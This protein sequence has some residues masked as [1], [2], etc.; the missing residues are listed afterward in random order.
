[1]SPYLMLSP[2][3]TSL[4]SLENNSSPNEKSLNYNYLYKPSAEAKL[5]DPLQ[6]LE[7]KLLIRELQ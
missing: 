3:E 1:M 6:S 4:W 2:I 5:E 7:S